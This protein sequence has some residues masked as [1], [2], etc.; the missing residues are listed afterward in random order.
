MPKLLFYVYFIF[1][2]NLAHKFGGSL[3]QKDVLNAEFKTDNLEQQHDNFLKNF[4]III[5]QKAFFFNILLSFTILVHCRTI[6][7]GLVYWF[8]V[9]F[10]DIINCI[11]KK[12]L[13]QKRHSEIKISLKKLMIQNSLVKVISKTID[14]FPFLCHEEKIDKVCQIKPNIEKIKIIK[15]RCYIRNIVFDIHFYTFY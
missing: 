11:I 15:Y 8:N 7:L 5:T 4:R 14:F 9:L 13:N 3:T 12:F 6:I 2:C 10:L 1:H